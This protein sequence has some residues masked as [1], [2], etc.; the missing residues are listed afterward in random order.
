MRILCIRFSGLP[1][2][3]RLLFTRGLARPI[4][5]S[6]SRILSRFSTIRILGDTLTRYISGLDSLI[7]SVLGG[8]KAVS[9]H[10]SICSSAVSDEEAFLVCR[11]WTL[12]SL[13]APAGLQKVSINSHQFPL[14]SIFCQKKKNSCGYLLNFVEAA[15]AAIGQYDG[16]YT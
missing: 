1:V 13:W 9:R 10:H 11:S 4:I 16:N 3:T 12:T 8:N 15:I 14:D 7:V 6:H 5:L 2:D